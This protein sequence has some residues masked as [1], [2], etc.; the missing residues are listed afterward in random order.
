MSL[1]R[2]PEYRDIGVEWLGEVAA[3]SGMEP[4]KRQFASPRQS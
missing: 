3:H 1:P 2:Y 4:F